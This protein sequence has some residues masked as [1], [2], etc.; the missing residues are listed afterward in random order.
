LIVIISL[1]Q[2][3]HEKAGEKGVISVDAPKIKLV[4]TLFI[5]TGLISTFIILPTKRYQDIFVAKEEFD[6]HVV[7]GAVDTAILSRNK[8]GAV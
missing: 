2:P 7:R 5:M 1:E 3:G 6:N 8:F 4:E